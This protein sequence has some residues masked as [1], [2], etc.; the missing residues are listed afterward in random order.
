MQLTLERGSQMHINPTAASNPSIGTLHPDEGLPA[1]FRHH[2]VLAPG[3]RLFRRIGFPAKSAWVSAAFLLPI[4]V[5]ALSLWLAASASVEFSARERLGVEFVRSMMPVLDA[6]QNRRRAAV[7]RAPDLDDAQ[8]KLVKAMEG[9][10]QAYARLGTLL[11]LEPAWSRVRELERTLSGSLVRADA[12]ATFG[13]HTEFVLALLALLNDVADN[14]NLTL[15]PDV[16]TFYLM[17][18]A[19]FRAPQLI[20]QLGQMRGMGN[21][22]LRAGEIDLTQREL[23]GSAFA[24]AKAHSA[25]LQKALK[26]AVAH[27]PTLAAEVQVE[28]ALRSSTEFLVL[29]RQQVLGGRPDGDPTAFVAAANRAIALHYATAG[30]VLDA[31]DTRISRRVD[32]LQRTLWLQLGVA[33][34]GIVVA[35]YLL[36]A[37]YRVTQGGIAEV[38]RQLDEMSRGNLSLQPKPWGRDEVSKLMNTLANTLTSLRT[39]VMQV[40]T[41][42]QE[43]E[44]ASSEV[45]SASMDLSRRTEETAAHLQRTSAAM[46]QIGTT[47]QH[48]A[49]T[50]AGANDIV[51]RNA[52]VAQKGGTE[53]GDMVAL[54]ADIKTA[55]DRIAEIS[56]TIDG[57]A[58]QTNI[59]ALNASV[60][61]AR[62]GEQGRGFAVVA[63]EVRALAQRSAG[64]AKEI[65][66]LIGASAEQVESGSR[67]VTLAG[68]TIHEIVDNAHSVKGLI[69]EIASGTHEQTAGLTEVGQSVERLDSMT[70]QNAALVEQTAAAAASLKDNSKRLAE[71]VAFFRI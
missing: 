70:Q 67:T 48:T 14:S 17:D 1:F 42:A 34:I 64:A 19:V 7:S 4:V 5:L 35:I 43:I 22:L 25:S 11:E 18:A 31:L 37:F 16:D 23:V 63:S 54:M 44:T 20:E 56:G 46:A 32:G 65:K 10:E 47:V 27:D 24:F 12:S 36:V 28:E 6:A 50:A 59:L 57:I 66:A 52:E 62:A 2:G 26:R 53:V 39:I 71:A 45:A 55:S 51:A 41:G 58:F 29:V 9:T 21:A 49:V 33:L 8:H 30:R 69:G 68:Q 13:A 60:E 40:R 61:A 3:V 38:A 15:D